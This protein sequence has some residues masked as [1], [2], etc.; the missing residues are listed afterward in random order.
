MFVRSSFS[1]H[2]MYSARVGLADDGCLFLKQGQRDAEECKRQPWLL[3]SMCESSWA[4]PAGG[5]FS[6]FLLVANHCSLNR[7]TPKDDWMFSLSFTYHV[8]NMLC[9]CLCQEIRFLAL[10]RFGSRRNSTTR[11][12][13]LDMPLSSSATHTVLVTLKIESTSVN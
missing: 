6:C 9:T 1:C 7:S 8:G 12:K 11:H 10:S 2:V 4:V 3:M 5:W 13:L